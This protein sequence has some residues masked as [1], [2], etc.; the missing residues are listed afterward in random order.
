MRNPRDFH[1]PPTLPP[2]QIFFL[3]F[4]CRTSS[5]SCPPIFSSL[6]P[7]KLPTKGKQNF[8]MFWKA[9][10]HVIFPLQRKFLF[11]DSPIFFPTQE[12][13]SSKRYM[14][15]CACSSLNGIKSSADLFIRNFFFWMSLHL[16][17]LKRPKK[18]SSQKHACIFHCPTYYPQTP[19]TILGDTRT[20]KDTKS[21]SY[22]DFNVQIIGI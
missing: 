10:S 19:K 1:K 8:Y 4:Y 6:E 15:V 17:T 18:K 20:Q 14:Q 11:G 5:F 2:P 12:P 13:P 22:R 3:I 16:F 7:S 9:S 21:P